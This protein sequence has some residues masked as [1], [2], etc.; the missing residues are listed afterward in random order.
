[1]K[2]Q[3]NH[4][5]TCGTELEGW[6]RF[7]RS[8]GAE[9]TVA[10]LSTREGASGS[11]EEETAVSGP[12]VEQ[13][14]Q[15]PTPSEPGAVDS[16][17]QPATASQRPRAGR[18][19]QRIV[20]AVAAIAGALVLLATVAGVAVALDRGSSK[21]GHS[22][23]GTSVPT[24]L[25]RSLPTTV[26]ALFD[27]LRPPNYIRPAYDSACS[28]VP[29]SVPDRCQRRHQNRHQHL[30]GERGR[31]WFPAVADVSSHRCPCR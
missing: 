17:P 4:C 18:R 23:S 7:C 20:W 26:P 30:F 25:N 3:R 16:R 13:T 27:D 2:P 1:M 14:P 29:A 5:P 12:T 24:T 15:W 22:A 11:R 19:P 28:D 21:G 10:D 9:L 8:C 31:V 6:E